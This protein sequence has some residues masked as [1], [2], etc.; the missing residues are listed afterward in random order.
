M[1]LVLVAGAVRAAHGAADDG[2]PALSAIKPSGLEWKAGTHYEVLSTAPPA[3]LSA[4][5]VEILE[6]FQY[7]CPHCYTVEPHVV[8]WK[9]TFGNLATITR[10]P[11]TFRA[12]LRSLA[13]LYYTLEAL[14]RVDAPGLKDVHHEVFDALLRNGERLMS[15]DEAEDF[16]AQ[17]AFAVSAGI[18]AAQFAA[19]WRSEAVQQKVERAE[20]LVITYRVAS[21]PTFVVGRKYKT[22]IRAAGDEYRLM[23]LLTDL[24]LMSH[25]ARERALTSR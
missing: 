13:R 5:K 20:E 21:T 10:I 7:G 25:D 22:D 24:A 15:N 17:Q 19:A 16:K 8:L 4:G 3:A 11:V 12:P 18:D 1:G 14:G 2:M 23:H 6:F 9:R